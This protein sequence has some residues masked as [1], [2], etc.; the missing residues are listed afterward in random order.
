MR[1]SY[2]QDVIDYL[3]A[4]PGEFA[5]G[6]SLARIGG[7][8]A[9]RTRVSEARHRLLAEG[10]GDIANVQIKLAD[11][12]V[13]SL[14]SFVPAEP[15]EQAALPWWPASATGWSITCCA[16]STRCG[17]AGAPPPRPGPTT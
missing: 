17:P 16:C 13:Q 4:K 10:R 11:G 12:R 6:L 7:A 1:H 15:T 2:T 14:Y 3:T 9:W 8:Y 5:D